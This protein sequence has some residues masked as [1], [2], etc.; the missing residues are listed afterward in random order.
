VYS[1][2]EHVVFIILCRDVEKKTSK[3]FHHLTLCLPQLNF[4]KQTIN[5]INGLFYDNFQNSSEHLVIYAAHETSSLFF[6]STLFWKMMVCSGGNVFFFVILCHFYYHFPPTTST[7]S[8]KVSKIFWKY[9][10]FFYVK[11]L[12]T[13]ISVSRCFF[14][15]DTIN[16]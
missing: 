14:Q 5:L 2:V 1:L 8:Y 10:M 4:T 12:I 15:R 7:S 3:R 9:L 11:K 16:I 13:N 6:L